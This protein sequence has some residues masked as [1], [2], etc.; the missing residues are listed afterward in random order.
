MANEQKLN[1]LLKLSFQGTLD[2]PQILYCETDIEFAETMI[3]LSKLGTE[4]YIEYMTDRQ[5]REFYL[6]ITDKGRLFIEAGGYTTQEKAL[7]EDLNNDEKT[8]KSMKSDLS[9]IL[10]ILFFIATVILSLVLYFKTK[11]VHQISYD[12][13]DS[14]S[15]IYDSS[16]KSSKIKLLERDSVPI[17]N[18]VYM[19]AGVIKNTGNQTINMEDFIKRTI[20]TLNLAEDNRIIDFNIVKQFEDIA[21]FNLVQVSDNSLQLSWSCFDPSFSM[22]FQIIYVGKSDSGFI[23]KGRGLNI[24]NFNKAKIFTKKD[25][26]F[27]AYNLDTV[28]LVLAISI[29]VL[30]MILLLMF[31][32]RISYKNRISIFRKNIIVLAVLIIYAIIFYFIFY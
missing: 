1:E 25:P 18:N 24:E 6:S 7:D 17:E 2:N 23:L 12:V 26:L 9:V 21:K 20:I 13:L 30:L 28:I 3:S 4:G 11:Q 8:S 31:Q 19:I 32:N 16:N 22:Q 15:L 5:K 27:A 29:S 10:G 14:P